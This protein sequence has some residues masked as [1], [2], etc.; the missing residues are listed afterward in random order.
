MKLGSKDVKATSYQCPP[1]VHPLEKKAD[2][3]VLQ[4]KLY[5]QQKKKIGQF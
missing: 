1:G 5:T 3:K 4:W 2:M